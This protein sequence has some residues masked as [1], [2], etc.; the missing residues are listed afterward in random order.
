MRLILFAFHARIQKSTKMEVRHVFN[1]GMETSNGIDH[2]TD[3]QG[4]QAQ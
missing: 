1:E 3:K 2:R 4:R